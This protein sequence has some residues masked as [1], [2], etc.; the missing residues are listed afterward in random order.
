M[1]RYHPGLAL[2]PA[3][4]LALC[5]CLS[6]SDD[7]DRLV[8][9]IQAPADLAIRGRTMQLS[10]HAWEQSESGSRR[11]VSGIRFDWENLSPGFVTLDARPDGTALLTPVGVGTARIAA[12]ARAFEHAEP[13]VID[14]RVA[15][16]VTIDSAR[17]T[18]VHYG[19]RLTVYGVG[20][21]EITRASLGPGD[22]LPD[23][24]SFAGQP[25]GISRLSFWVPYPAASG[26]L[27]ALSRQGTTASAPEPTE[28][29]PL[30][31][32]H[33][34]SIPPPVIDLAG[35]AVGMSDT[36][37]H[38]PAFALVDGESSDAL[39][40]QRPAGRS[41]T[42]FISSTG[43]V[44]TLFNPVLTADAVA[45]LVYRTA[46]GF[47][48][49]AIGFSDQYCGNLLVPLGRPAR[50]NAPVSL[51]RAFKDVPYA[52]LL[53]AAYGEPSGGYSVTVRDGYLTADPR[54][55]PDRFEENDY[56]RGADDNDADPS[57]RLALPFADTLTIDNFYE[58]DWFRFTI[59][60]FPGEDP[61]VLV[62]IRT[63]ARPFGASDSSD[64]GLMVADRAVPDPAIVDSARTVGSSA[65]R[66]TTDLGPGD[67]YVIVSDDGGV[68][69]RYS[70]CIAVGS[71]C[72][73][74]DEG[75]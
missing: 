45:P 14:L 26:P 48:T 51:V 8:V 43:P 32:Y 62:T 9:T 63:S 11:E 1:S 52:E 54:I 59:P 4:A 41:L 39:R 17:P 3:L 24:A 64:V 61:P 22:L 10:A 49:W 2:A 38:N 37:F 68:A 23:A 5:S 29:R 70:L 42:F 50:I 72:R 35:A 40:F 46:E 56:C 30:D 12:S 20:L 60:G 13:G 71:S 57:R 66:L 19:D 25:Q 6:P 75:P 33:E 67:Y 55:D 7:S 73:F 53:L 58:V 15:D 69:T 47:A 34:L 74:L 16:A 21:G 18:V 31:R 44:V 65:E 28:V 27:V 36:L